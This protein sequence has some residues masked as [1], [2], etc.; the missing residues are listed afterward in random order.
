MC[1][2]LSYRFSQCI[3]F[4]GCVYITFMLFYQPIKCYFFERP[5]DQR[6][7][8]MPT[9]SLPAASLRTVSSLPAARVL[10]KVSNYLIRRAFWPIGRSTSGIGS[11][12][13]LSSGRRREALV[14]ATGRRK[15][16]TCLRL[17][18]PQRRLQI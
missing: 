1:R 17:R 18:T 14:P 8:Q 3:G 9:Q 7:V 5:F 13:S 11:S 12:S 10:L 6:A 4:Y 16:F 15:F 2:F